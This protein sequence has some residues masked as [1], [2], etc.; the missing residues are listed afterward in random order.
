MFLFYAKVKQEIKTQTMHLLFGSCF[1]CKALKNSDGRLW[2]NVEQYTKF[3]SQRGRKTK[4]W[5]LAL[6]EMKLLLCKKTRAPQEITCTWNTRKKA[7]S[8]NLDERKLKKYT[9]PPK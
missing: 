3:H 7:T 4:V 9:Y 8:F 2:Q 6:S 1:C 5:N